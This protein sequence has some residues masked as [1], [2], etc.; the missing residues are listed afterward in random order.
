MPGSWLLPA[1][2]DGRICLVDELLRR[3]DLNI[4]GEYWP[5]S[6]RKQLGRRRA[7]FL[8]GMSF[9]TSHPSLL[10]RTGVIIA[11]IHALLPVFSVINYVQ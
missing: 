9:P 1:I 4:R 6:N 5:S 8:A 11:Q 7:E 10:R 2:G 3:Y